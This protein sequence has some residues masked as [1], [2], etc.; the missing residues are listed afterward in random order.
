MIDWV[1]KAIMGLLLSAIVSLG[2]Y[3]LFLRS[4]ITDLTKEVSDLTETVDNDKLIV[5]RLT[6]N[7]RDSNALIDR[8]RA[9][10]AEAKLLQDKKDG[11]IAEALAK[12]EEISK[13]HQ[14]YA[15]YLLA[16]IPKSSNMC[17]E[18]ED[19]INSYLAKERGGK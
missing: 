19:M 9:S 6:S 13:K 7:A 17:K 2:G 3:V 4:E 5:D 16:T 12:V 14:S 1:N 10:L 8:F 18:A 11:E 15:S